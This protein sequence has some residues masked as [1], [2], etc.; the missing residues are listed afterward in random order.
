MTIGFKNNEIIDVYGFG[1]QLLG[2]ILKRR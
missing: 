2:V 1:T